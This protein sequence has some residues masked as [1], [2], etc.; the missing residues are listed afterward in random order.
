M[1][2]HVCEFIFSNMYDDCEGK[3]EKENERRKRKIEIKKN[4]T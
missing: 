2:L 1:A 3:N 4:G